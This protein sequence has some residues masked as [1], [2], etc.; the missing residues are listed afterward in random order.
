M[1]YRQRKNISGDWNRRRLNGA[2]AFLAA[3]N[4]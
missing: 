4:K 1:S 3:D 2:A